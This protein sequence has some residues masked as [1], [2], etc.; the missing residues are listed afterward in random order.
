MNEDVFM[1]NAKLL[2]LECRTCTETHPADRTIDRQPKY[3]HGRSTYT[4]VDLHDG[5]PTG[6]PT[7]SRNTD[8]DNWLTTPFKYSLY[9]I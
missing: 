6:S 2:T 8:V 3:R 9:N 5:R 4:T 1:S 7:H